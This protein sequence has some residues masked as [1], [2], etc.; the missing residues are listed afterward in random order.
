MGFPPPQSLS[1]H[2]LLQPYGVFLIFKLNSPFLN[3]ICHFC[4]TRSI[5]AGAQYTLHIF[6]AAWVTF[7]PY[8]IKYN[9]LKILILPLP[10]YFAHNSTTESP[11]RTNC[12]LKCSHSSTIQE[13]KNTQ[14]WNGVKFW[15][16]TI[17]LL[18]L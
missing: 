4:M 2:Q 6:T 12:V 14:T 1:W 7:V 18:T 13:E 5:T 10:V 17:I 11:K 3:Q 16:V 9:M 8:K 15:E